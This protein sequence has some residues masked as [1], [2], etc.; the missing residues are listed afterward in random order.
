MMK[1]TYI[2]PSVRTLHF[3]HRSSLL[4][5]SRV[6]FDPTKSGNTQRSI[7]RGSAIWGDDDDENQQPKS[8]IWQ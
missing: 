8:R 1:K 2:Q 6:D 3:A 4:D 7:K 5:S